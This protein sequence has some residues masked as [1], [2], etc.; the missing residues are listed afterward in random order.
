ML[1]LP[2]GTA[3]LEKHPFTTTPSECYVQTL[4]NTCLGNLAENNLYGSAQG[5]QKDYSVYV[6]KNTVD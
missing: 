3:A 4:A 2:Q 1:I 5:D 6:S